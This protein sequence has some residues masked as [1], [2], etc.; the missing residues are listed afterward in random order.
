[1]TAW[2]AGYAP[3]LWRPSLCEVCLCQTRE[4]LWLTG[5]L[6]DETRPVVVRSRNNSLG[7][8]QEDVVGEASI[9]EGALQDCSRGGQCPRRYAPV[10]WQVPDRSRPWIDC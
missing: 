3:G 7:L 9:Q 8:S 1:M 5:W 6:T 2:R 10:A 4:R